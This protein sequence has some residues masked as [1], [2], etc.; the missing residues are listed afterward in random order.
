M[1]SVR[2]SEEIDERKVVLNNRAMANDGVVFERG[3]EEKSMSLDRG[4]EM[5]EHRG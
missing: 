4:V 5:D 2:S 3:A 1:E